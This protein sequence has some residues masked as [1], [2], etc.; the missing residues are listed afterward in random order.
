MIVIYGH[1]E[2]LLTTTITNNLWCEKYR[3]RTLDQYVFQ[4][5][6]HRA[7]FQQMV[8]DKSIPQL[9]LAG[10]Q[11]TGKTTIAQILISAMQLDPADVLTINASNERGIDTF[12][13]KIMNFATSMAMGRFKIVY[14][15]EADQLTPDAQKALKRFMEDVSD[16]VRFLLTANHVNKIIPPIRSRCQEF[17][18]K[19]ADSVDITEAMATVLLKEGVSFELEVLDR[20]VQSGY[21]DM[22]KIINNLQQN[23]IQS[24]LLSP[25]TITSSK[26]WKLELAGLIEQSDW[27]AAR[28]LACQ[29][30]STEEWEDLYRF[31]YE[32]LER[33]PA[34]KKQDS[35][36]A[37]VIIIADH[38]YRHTISADPEINAASMFIQLSQL[39]K[40]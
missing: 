1:K 13:D 9:L 16:S 11:G 7:A 31:L 6:Q 35:W 4:N 24:K 38:L 10:I 25:N 33:F 26:D 3:P 34:F 20:Y 39:E 17:T 37:A 14:L 23:T 27:R 8:N 21:P 15:E 29:S 36:D 28:Q 19:A 18:F 5:T 2:F 40:L 12:R 32:N 22:R 30:V